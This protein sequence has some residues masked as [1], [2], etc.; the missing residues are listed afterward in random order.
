MSNY[1]GY[2]NLYGPFQN[3]V[4]SIQIPS[5]PMVS[6]SELQA[7]SEYY[8]L[9]APLEIHPDER[10]TALRPGSLQAIH[11][12]A[13]SHASAR[14]R[15][16]HPDTLG[17]FPASA[18]SGTG[19]LHGLQVFDAEGQILLQKACAS[20]PV[21]VTPLPNGFRLT[22]MGHFLED[23]LGGTVMDVSVSDASSL[24]TQTHVEGFH[25]LTQCLSEDINEDGYTDLLL[26]GFGAGIEGRVSLF[27]GDAQGTFKEETILLDHAGALCARS[28]D[29]DQD[30]LMDLMI[31][32]A[33]QHQELLLFTQQV[34]G[35]FERSVLIKRGAGYG[36]NGFELVDW[37]QDER[38]D[39]LMVNG[40][41]M[42]IRNA[43]IK[44]YHGIRIL[45]Q[46]QERTFEEALFYPFPGAIKALATD[47]DQDGDLDVAA[48]AFYPDW[49]QEH[50]L[51]FVY[52]EQKEGT[53]TASTTALKDWG[54][55]MTMDAGD[56][57]QDSY[58]DLILG[59]AYVKHSVH[60]LH[61]AHYQSLP[62]PSILMLDNIG[63]R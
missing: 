30:G 39:L 48:I 29:L 12:P 21:D 13:S 7:I 15:N 32:T 59:G 44:N 26:V 34:D 37:N 42:E 23:R 41:N 60:D 9:Y 36:Y 27:W 53:L 62:H 2:T 35:D 24:N 33:Q 54:R 61:Q 43:P 51:T 25:R 31:L 56:F 3:N 19:L 14:G 17:S 38:V 58:P 4:D 47:F 22:L 6:E 5:Q 1:L 16:H 28:A 63:A 11:S 10:T 55:W 46:T 49:S 57:N 8:L 52:L 45:Q 20:E 50:P 18:L 40:N